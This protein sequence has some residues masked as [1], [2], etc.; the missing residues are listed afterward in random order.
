MVFFFAFYLNPLKSVGGEAIARQISW[1]KISNEVVSFIL[2][3]SWLTLSKICWEARIISISKPIE[4]GYGNLGFWMCTLGYIYFLTCMFQ[5]NVA[6]NRD[7][8]V[9]R[10]LVICRQW[11]SLIPLIT[12]IH[13]LWCSSVKLHKFYLMVFENMSQFRCK[14]HVNNFNEGVQVI[15]IFTKL[16]FKTNY[17]IK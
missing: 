2:K 6:K 11:L 12:Q 15:S 8:T 1:H 17:K 5:S 3:L 4:Y 9:G 7:M 14:M 10:F 13:L 16:N